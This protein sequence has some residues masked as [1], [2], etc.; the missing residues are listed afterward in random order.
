MKKRY[1]C[2][3][4]RVSGLAR[5]DESARKLEEATGTPGRGRRRLPG[6]TPVAPPVFEELEGGSYSIDR[7]WFVLDKGVEHYGYGRAWVVG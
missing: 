5:S 1:G 3:A 6:W 4:H 7:T 2:A